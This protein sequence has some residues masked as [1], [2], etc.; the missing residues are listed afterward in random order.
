[1]AQDLMNNGSMALKHI[2]VRWNQKM[3]LDDITFH[4]PLFYLRNRNV[5]EV[6]IFL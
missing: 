1:M 4:P 2:L 3:K 5:S 6:N